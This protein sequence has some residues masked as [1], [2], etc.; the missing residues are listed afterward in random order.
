MQIA[1][2]S[3]CS[4]R[5]LLLLLSGA[6]RVEGF[7]FFFLF[8]FLPGGTE[9]SHT[10]SGYKTFSPLY[11]DQNYQQTKSCRGGR[12]PKERR[13]PEVEDEP[14]G[15]KIGLLLTVQKLLGQKCCCLFSDFCSRVAVGG[16][17]MSSVYSGNMSSDHAKSGCLIQG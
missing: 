3:V 16:Y 12:K 8:C 2:F 4:A 7:F 6:D 9:A 15:E 10:C 17:H 5:L 11:K 1:S 14:E 13:L